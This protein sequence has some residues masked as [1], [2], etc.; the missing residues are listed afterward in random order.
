MDFLG[1]GEL[2]LHLR[3]QG[4]ILEKVKSLGDNEQLTVLLGCPFLSR[5]NDIS[6][7]IST[8]SG[9]ELESSSFTSDVTLRESSTE[10]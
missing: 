10:I 7:W 4:L 9:Q 3:K 1:G 6:H 8:F 5:G 2:F